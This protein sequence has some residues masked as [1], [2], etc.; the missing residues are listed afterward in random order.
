[1]K[2]LANL[3]ES[4][5]LSQKN[6]ADKLDIRYTTYYGYESGLHAPDIATLKKLANF[7]DVSIDYL[8]E[9]DNGEDFICP[10]AINSINDAITFLNRLNLI[11]YIQNK[12]DNKIIAFAKMLLLVFNSFKW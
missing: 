11:K 3:R 9:N 1:M 2:R 12:E 7:F 10:E 4:N 6:L 5:N 8:V